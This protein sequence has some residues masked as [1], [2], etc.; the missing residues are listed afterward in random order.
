MSEHAASGETH[1]TAGMKTMYVVWAGLLVATLIEVFL[2]YLHVPLLFMLIAL[3]GLSVVKAF[4][5]M[6]YFMHLKFESMNLILTLIPA[7]VLT[8]LLMN[9]FY[10]DALRIASHGIGR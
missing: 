5:I 8:I 7:M 3:L 1:T 4:L 2:A 6:A 10:P 9:I